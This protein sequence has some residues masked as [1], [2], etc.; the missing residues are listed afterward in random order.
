M[1]CPADLVRH[2]VPDA[3]LA[4]HLLVLP[5]FV[6]LGVPEVVRVVGGRPAFLDRRDLQPRAV[7]T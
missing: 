1:A 4:V 2:G 6:Q 5:A 7:Q 3:G